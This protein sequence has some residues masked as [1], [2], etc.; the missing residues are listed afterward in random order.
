MHSANVVLPEPAWP[1]K[2]I[3]FTCEVSN[4]GMAKNFKSDENMLFKFLCYVLYSSAHLS[5]C[6]SLVGRVILLIFF[7]IQNTYGTSNEVLHICFRSL[8]FMT[9][10]KPVYQM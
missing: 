9:A 5:L 7:Y 10:K 2:T 6:H 8:F 4:S 3:L 1:S